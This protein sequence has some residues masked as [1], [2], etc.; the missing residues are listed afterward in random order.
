MLLGRPASFPGPVGPVL[1]EI[2]PLLGASMPPRKG[3]NGRRAGESE[4]TPDPIIALVLWW[5]QV[6][7]KLQFRSRHGSIVQ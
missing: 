1:G 4:H 2:V 6:A 3:L 7:C 5:H